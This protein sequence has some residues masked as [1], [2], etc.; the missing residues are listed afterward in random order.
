M[1]GIYYGNGWNARSLP[2]MSTKLLLNNGTSYPVGDVF[3][4]GVLD[5]SALLKYGLPKLSGTFAFAMFMANAA[6][7]FESSD[8]YYQFIG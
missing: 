4:G 7:S 8:I 1:L 2:F 5:E 6:V 3:V